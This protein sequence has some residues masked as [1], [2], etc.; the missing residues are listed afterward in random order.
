MTTRRRKAYLWGVAAEH[1]AAALLIA[2][3]YR[4]LHRRWRCPMGE[5][6]LVARRGR[7]VVFIEVKA[8]PHADGGLESITTKQ[9]GR[10]ERS[11]Q[12]FLQQF[13]QNT[14]EARFDVI[15]CA[16]WKLPR[17]YPNAWQTAGVA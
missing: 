5:I 17:H 14:S 13:S 2:K 9:R 15:A 12:M 1:L 10:I 4:I 7:Q 16:P 8:R 3:G 11:A 6:D